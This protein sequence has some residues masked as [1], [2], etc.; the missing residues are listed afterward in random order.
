LVD[1]LG[2]VVWSV[3]PRQD[4]LASVARRIGEFAADVLAGQ[5]VRWE[6]RAPPDLERV[7]LD[8]E[9]RRHLYLILKEAVHNAARHAA[10]RSLSL[11]VEVAD[12]VLTA[13]VSDDG[14]GFRE[15]SSDGERAGHGLPNMRERARQLGGELSIESSP[16]GTR[17]R[18]RMPVRG[19]E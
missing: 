9:R 7:R 19:I 2:D 18:L 1:A 12:G 14:R 5:G 15:V 3:D 16:G 6:L 8:P 10:G 4:D 13:E 11:R 17:V